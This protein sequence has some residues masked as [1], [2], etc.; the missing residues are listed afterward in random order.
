MILG[1]VQG[2]EQKQMTAEYESLSFKRRRFFVFVKKHAVDHR[3]KSGYQSDWS[4]EQ[5]V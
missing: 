4:L 5:T 3:D 2:W 1:V